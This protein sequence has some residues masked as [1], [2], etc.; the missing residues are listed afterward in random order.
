METTVRRK[1]LG[2]VDQ[3]ETMFQE[4]ATSM[5]DWE[6]SVVRVERV[7]L[8]E[9]ENKVGHDDE[10]GEDSQCRLLVK[11]S[12]SSREKIEVKSVSKL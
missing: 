1:S 4:H 2:V 5:A 6:A 8:L 10:D 3:V 11:E 12:R 9:V 7:V